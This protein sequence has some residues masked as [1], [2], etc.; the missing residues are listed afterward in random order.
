LDSTGA[1][2]LVLVMVATLPKGVQRLVFSFRRNGFDIGDIRMAAN[3]ERDLWLNI[4]AWSS[5][6]I[7]IGAIVGQLIHRLKTEGE[8]LK[9]L[10]QDMQAENAKLEEW[11]AKLVQ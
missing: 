1:A 5:L 9:R 2:W 4:L 10:K 8:Q 11:V 7:L 6:L 3:T